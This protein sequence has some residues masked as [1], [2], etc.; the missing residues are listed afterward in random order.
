MSEWI[1]FVKEVQ[2]KHKCSYKEALKIASK[3]YK[4]K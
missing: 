1:K 2:A 4:K 3:E